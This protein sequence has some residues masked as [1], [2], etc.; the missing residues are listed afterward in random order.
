MI[1]RLRSRWSAQAPAWSEKRRF[2]ASSAATRYPIWAAFASSVEHGDERQGDQADLVAEQRDRLAEPETAELRVL[3]QEARHDHRRRTLIS[4]DAG[5]G[6]PDR[7][8]RRLGLHLRAG[9]G[10]AGALS[11]LRLP[12]RPLRDRVARARGSGRRAHALTGTPG[13][14]AGVA[15][16]LLLAVGYALQ[17]AGLERTT[18]SSAGFITGL[19]VVFTP[20]LALLLF[21]TRVGRAVWIGVALAVVGLAML[22]GVGTGDPVGDLLVL[23]GS[24]AY[25][26]QIVLMERYAPRYDPVAFTQA[27][28][29]A[30]FAGFAVVAVALGQVEL[31]RGWT[32]WGALLVTGIFASALAFLVQTWAQQRASA[33]QTA[34]AFAMEPVFA[35]FFGFWLAGDRLGAVGW[36]GCALIM[37][38]IVV[39]EPEAG[40]TLR[41][42]V[43]PLIRSGTQRPGTEHLRPCGARV[44][45]PRLC[46]DAQH[47]VQPGV[48]G[49][50]KRDV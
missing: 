26:V 33:T 18:V 31:P 15:L 5:P 12:R 43:G 14:V 17:T 46:G 34:L 3:A 40:R 1:C 48:D 47:R 41:R 30:A 25:S 36:G 45:V 7:R 9:E 22:S 19:Y 35:G 37:A 27:E 42:L 6:R 39:A 13:W 32:V 20:L 8:H 23:A 28:M 21:R 44:A 49:G 50:G 2:G 11:A 29:L 38:G 24:A 16:G 4:R 10:R